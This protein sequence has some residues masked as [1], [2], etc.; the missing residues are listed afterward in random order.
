MMET[1]MALKI[2]RRAFIATGAATIAL[3][4]HDSGWTQTWP[5]RPIKIVCAYPAGGLADTL[6]RVYGEYLSQKLGQPVIVENKAGASG[7]IAAAAVK[8]SPPDGYTLL[9]AI[10][11]TLVQSRVLFKTLP[12]DADRDFALISSMSAGYLPL[13]AYKATN[14]TNL[15]EFVEYARRNVTNVGT[16]GAGSYPHIVVAE[17]NKQYGLQM[18]AVHYRGEAPMWQ[19]LAAGVLQA[20]MGS[21]ANAVNALESGVGRAIAVQT[22]TRSRKLPDV[23]TFFEQ[24]AESEL[25][26]MTGYVF[27]A[28]PIGMPQDI[29]ERVSGLMVEAG[30]TDKIQK[31]LDAYGID[32]SAQGHIAFRRLYDSETPP[33]VAAVKALG[34]TPE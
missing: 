31:L 15:K 19:D 9:L 33:L 28:G 25:F 20:A 24:G 10:T 12:Y 1:V 30:K 7:S 18:K 32:E 21:Y 14:A 5:S 26:A 23:P 17:L 6:A 11:A 13:V 27:L 4:Y 29:V 34:L 3:S 2:T 16:F 22:R 8:Q